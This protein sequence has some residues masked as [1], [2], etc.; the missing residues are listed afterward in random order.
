MRVG[1]IILC[2]GR[3]TRMG[4]PKAWL[5]IGTETL[6]ARTVRVVAAVVSPVAVVAA[7]DQRLPPLPPDIL[8]LR[9]EIADQGPL[10]GLVSGL[11]AL[12]GTVDAVFLT[13]CDM[14]FLT[15]DCV[16]DTVTS[17]S[18]T[19]AITVPEADG[20]CHPLAAVYALSLLPSLRERLQSGQLRMMD[21]LEHAATRVLPVDPQPLRNVNTPA[22][23]AALGRLLDAGS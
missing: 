6:L 15:S 14:P 9:D 18:P 7:V 11:A 19:V 4:T 12:T 17:H 3:S 22:E 13:A 10:G 8:I 21:L 5:P 1:G 20:R 16:R 23:Y 2:G